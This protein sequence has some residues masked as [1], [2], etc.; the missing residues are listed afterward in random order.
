MDVEVVV[1]VD[2]VNE[3]ERGGR[4]DVEATGVAGIDDDDDEEDEEEAI[5][6]MDGVSAVGL[7]TEL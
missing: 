7:A 6:I 4:V 2:A 1:G 5:D 3:G